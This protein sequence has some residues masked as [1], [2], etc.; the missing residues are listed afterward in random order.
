MNIDLSKLVS[1]T[2]IGLVEMGATEDEI[3]NQVQAMFYEFWE[4]Q[5]TPQAIFPSWDKLKREAIALAIR[6]YIHHRLQRNV[7]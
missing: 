4:E 6:T 2:L 7:T 1:A 5:I 3:V